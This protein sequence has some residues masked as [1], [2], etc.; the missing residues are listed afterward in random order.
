MIYDVFG[1]GWNYKLSNF[2]MNPIKDIMSEFVLEW[3]KE[4]NKRRA[5]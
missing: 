3:K 5:K 4:N 2:E 1:R